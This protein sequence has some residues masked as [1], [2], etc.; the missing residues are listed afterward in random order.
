MS[1][2]FKV[3]ESFAEGL[4][5]IA[6]EQT[7]RV[8]ACLQPDQDVHKGVHEARKS[9][10]R[11]RAL[12][13]L[14]QAGLEEEDY[15]HLDHSFRDIARGL[16][17]T[18]EIQGMLDSLQHLE[19]RF[20]RKARTRVLLGLRCQL[21]ASRSQISSQGPAAAVL[22]KADIVQALDD[23]SKQIAA[24]QVGQDDFEAI[25]PGLDKTYRAARRGHK[26][27]FDGGSGESFHEWRKS[28]QRHWRH[29][30][31]L[32]AAW[33]HEL[34]ARA[35]LLRDITETVGRDHDLTVL[36]HYL[37]ESG[38]TLGTAI[39]VRAC[40]ALCRQH[41]VEL[42]AAVRS[43]GGKLFAEGASAFS[44]RVGRYWQ[45]ACVTDKAPKRALEPVGGA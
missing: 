3:S 10:K 38:R 9:L 5:R 45:M 27:A 4:G 41:Q 33:P 13:A 39:Q 36:D 14:Y 43:D 30:Q 28:L 42:R 17:V 32:T 29:M 16:S 18:R 23:A 2:K 21:E 35:Q 26:Q 6:S 44:K 24:I 8:R 37:G 22:S 20:G 11:L 7:D 12:L 15:R 1:Y 25:R 31:L 34:R 40:Q 19:T